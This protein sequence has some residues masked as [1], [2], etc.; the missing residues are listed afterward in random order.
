MIIGRESTK[1]C[2]KL[3]RYFALAQFD[4]A[5]TA[6]VPPPPPPLHHHYHHHHYYY[7][8]YC[9]YL[10]EFFSLANDRFLRVIAIRACSPDISLFIFFFFSVFDGKSIVR[11]SISEEAGKWYGERRHGDTRYRL[12][13]IDRRV[14]NRRPSFLLPSLIFE[15]AHGIANSKRI[16]RSSRCADPFPFRP[17]PPSPLPRRIRPNHL[18]TFF[19]TAIACSTTPIEISISSL[20]RR[21]ED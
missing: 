6:C 13:P 5:L 18:I 10:V 11:V 16:R 8:Y 9:Y 21:E 17:T 19:S 15:N 3:A 12:V 14:L 20:I 7:Y 2:A 1:H 4:R